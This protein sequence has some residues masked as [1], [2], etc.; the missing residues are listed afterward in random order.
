MWPIFGDHE[1]LPMMLVA[2]SAPFAK[3]SA[4]IVPVFFL[5]FDHGAKK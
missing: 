2:W 5:E 3:L 4:F 1:N